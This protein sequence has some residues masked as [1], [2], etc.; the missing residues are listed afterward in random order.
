MH[1]QDLAKKHDAQVFAST[2][3]AEAAGYALGQSLQ[4]RNAWNRDSAAQSIF[5]DL[6]RR[7]R[8]GELSEIGLVL[9]GYRVTGAYKTMNAEG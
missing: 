8:G 4:P 3:A 6:L 7:K 1:P 9:D 5:Y 2:E